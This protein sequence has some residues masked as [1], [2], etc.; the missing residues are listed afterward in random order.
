MCE[1][2]EDCFDVLEVFFVVSVF[3]VLGVY[4][5]DGIEGVVVKDEV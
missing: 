4:Y 2:G 3:V 5:F 1:Y